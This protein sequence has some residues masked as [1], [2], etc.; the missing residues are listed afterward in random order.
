[1]GL[2]K[3]VKVQIEP[4]FRSAECTAKLP[5]IDPED[6]TCSAGPS[7]RVEQSNRSRQLADEVGKYEEKGNEMS[8]C[9]V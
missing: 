1:L 3:M 7:F 4:I 9:E 2:V 6:A 8:V 5:E